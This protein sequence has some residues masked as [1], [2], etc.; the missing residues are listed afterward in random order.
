MWKLYPRVLRDVSVMDL[1]SRVLGQRVAVPVCVAA[2]AMQR[3][4]H[5]HGETATARACQAVGTGMML[6]SWA[7][8]SIEEVAAAAPSG[9]RWLQLYA[10]KER[11]VTAS[12]VRRAERAGYRGIFLTV[13]T[14]YLGRRLADVRN[15]FQLPPHLSLKNF[16]SSEL[17][18]SSGKDFG[19][20]SGLAVYVAEAIDATVSWEDVKWLRGLTS[21]PIVLKGI[22]RADDAKEAVKLGVNGILVSNHGARQLDGVPATIDV[23]PEIVEAVEGKVEVFLDGGVRKGTD[24]LKALALGAK[25]VFV[26]R[27]VL[28]GLAYQGEEGVKEVLQMLKEEFRL[29]MA[30]TGCRRVE[31]IGRTLIRRHQG[32]FSKI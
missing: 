5:P 8:S 11:Q 4:A 29:A 32:L 18:F 13:D 1:S 22:L 9:L 31:E 26:G 17:A 20:D 24:V 14:P 15:R 6:S 27:P 30:L 23:L 10:Y 21:L 3:M 12:L 25:A 16:S 28:W 2:T 7:T 19:D